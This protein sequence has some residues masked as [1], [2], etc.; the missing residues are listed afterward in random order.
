MPLHRQGTT[1]EIAEVKVNVP[2]GCTLK[3]V[4]IWLGQPPVDSPVRDRG[5]SASFGSSETANN[6]PDIYTDPVVPARG[7]IIGLLLSGPLWSLIG[8]GVWVRP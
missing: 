8:L 2:E 6:D 7:I 3:D 4:K 5:L 1:N